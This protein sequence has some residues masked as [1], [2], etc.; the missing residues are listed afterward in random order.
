MNCSFE[1]VVCGS[2]VPDPLQTLEPLLG[3]Q[4]PC[5]KNEALLPGILDPWAGHALF[6]AARLAQEAPPSRVH[7]VAV[8]PKGKLQQVLMSVAQRARFELVAVDT[9]A[10]GFAEPA[11]VAGA[12][13]QA[14]QG[15]PGIDKQRL[16]LFGGWESASRGAGATLSMTGELLGIQE[17]FQG[18]DR[19][20]V[21]PDGSFEILERLLGGSH[22][23]SVCSGP[24]AVFGWATGTLPEP[25]QNPQIGM[26]NMRT[27]LPALQRASRTDLPSAGVSFESLRV[28]GQQRSTLVVNDK[29]PDWVAR[30]I[31]AWIHES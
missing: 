28:P 19:L 18:V 31:V 30:D 4:G 12:L 24:P 11:E 8:G 7:L 13:A 6:E 22:Q 1:I 26:A 16:L 23:V 10:S 21:N 15:I 5:L 3:P 17:Q 25:V 27:A 9:T 20:T 2:A 14:I 29:D